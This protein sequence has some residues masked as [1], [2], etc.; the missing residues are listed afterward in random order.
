VKFVL[1]AEARLDLRDIYLYSF[2]EFGEKRADSYVSSLY[3]IFDMIGHNPEI[4]IKPD[5][6]IRNDVRRF[7]ALKHV[8]YY[9]TGEEKPEIRRIFH[10]S[11]EINEIEMGSFQ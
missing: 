7:P 3:D 8:I 6:K 10:S 2:Y 1:S 4:G 11:R 5:F 9:V